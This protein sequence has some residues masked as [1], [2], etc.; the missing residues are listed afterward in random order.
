MNV[1][2]HKHKG[3]ELISVFGAVFAEQIKKKIGIRANLKESATICS[4][5]SRKEGSEF[6][7]GEKHWLEA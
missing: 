6:L 2:R 7:R 1:V 3:V 5:S 4:D